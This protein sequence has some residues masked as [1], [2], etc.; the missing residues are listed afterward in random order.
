[1]TTAIKFQFTV[2]QHNKLPKFQ[3]RK[4]SDVYIIISGKILDNIT[5]IQI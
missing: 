4:L 5:Q 1:M 2:V 3:K